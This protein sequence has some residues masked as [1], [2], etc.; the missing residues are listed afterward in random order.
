MLVSKQMFY[1]YNYIMHIANVPFVVALA[2]SFASGIIG[3]ILLLLR[4]C[5]NHYKKHKKLKKHYKPIRA[6]S[7]SRHHIEKRLTKLMHDWKYLIIVCLILSFTNVTQ[8]YMIQKLYAPIVDHTF[9][10][11]FVDQLIKLPLTLLFGTILFKNKYHV[12]SIVLSIFITIIGCLSWLIFGFESNNRTTKNTFNL[13]CVVSVLLS[14]SFVLKKD[15][16]SKKLNEFELLIAISL[17]QIP[18]DILFTTLYHLYLRHNI[19]FIN[20]DV[21]YG[22]YCVVGIKMKNNIDYA[23]CTTQSLHTLLCLVISTFFMVFAQHLLIKRNGVVPYLILETICLP[24][25]AKAFMMYP[26]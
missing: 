10:M 13:R 16:L 7:Y 2:I 17:I 20:N 6:D 15:L 9:S 24:F 23:N 8:I 4:Y 21:Y 14:L 22:F 5:W 18:F 26:T 3:F 11:F 12:A 1:G 25:V 19:N